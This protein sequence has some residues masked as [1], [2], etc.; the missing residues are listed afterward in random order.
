[1]SPPSFVRPGH[2]VAGSVTVTCSLIADICIDTGR[3]C[4]ATYQALS[5]YYYHVYRV[6]WCVYTYPASFP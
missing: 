3:H 4:S 1:M 5:M 6:I 2:K